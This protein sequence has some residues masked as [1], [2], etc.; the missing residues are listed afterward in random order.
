M[1]ILV[2]GGTGFLGGA[3]ALVARAAGHDVTVL[4]RGETPPGHDIAMIRA[5]R[6]DLPDLPPFDAV[7]DTCAYAPGMVTA[8]RSAIGA[9]HYVIVSSISVYDALPEPQM[10]ETALASA[11]DGAALALAA[12][13][14][15]M[16]RANAAAYG[17]AYGPLKR[18]CEE[19]AGRATVLRLGL[20]V[21]PGDY[22]DR[23][24][25]WVRRMD[26]GGV[27]PVPHPPERPLQVIDVRDAARFALHLA[28]QRGV[29]TFNLTGPA[30]PFETI[31][32]QMA[33]AAGRTPDLEW[34]GLDQFTNEGIEPW[35]DLPLVV[36][37]TTPKRHMMDVSIE[38]AKAA[39]L[40]C[41]PL[42]ETIH[43]VLTWDR[44][45]RDTPLSAGMSAD[46]EARVLAG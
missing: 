21:G 35:V 3:I 32:A 27:V 16:E 36:P 14:P 41:R 42:S 39:G 20:I 28:E 8:L 24:T 19:V 22:T 38:R 44:S 1:R 2:V 30:R 25:W 43:D 23:F 40:T 34:C 46:Q 33:D 17:A 7:L 4:A 10:D 26:Q 5:D 13:V 29:G 45:R 12:A 9:A 18:A 15:P 11:A 31:L 6:M 37:T